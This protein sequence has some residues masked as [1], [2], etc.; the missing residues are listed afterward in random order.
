[1][2]LLLLIHLKHQ[3]LEFIHQNQ[4]KSILLKHL[5]KRTNTINYYYY[6]ALLNFVFNKKN[7]YLLDYSNVIDIN[8]RIK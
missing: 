4:F 1:L 3:K 7:I 8:N 5:I 2:Q 6:L